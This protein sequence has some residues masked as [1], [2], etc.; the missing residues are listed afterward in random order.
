MRSPHSFIVR[1]KEARYKRAVDVG[2]GK[3]LEVTASIENAKDVDKRAVV[4]ATP[5]IYDG[6]I[7][8][9]DEVIIHHNIFR[10]YYNSKGKLTYTRAYLYD[11]LFYAADFEVFM[12][13]RD[14]RWMPHGGYTFVSP[15]WEGSGEIERKQ[16]HLG[17]VVASNV[18]PEGQVVGFTPESEYNI[19]IQRGIELYRMR[20]E[21]ICLYY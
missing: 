18:H 7:R 13:N 5:L 9:G 4:V 12:Y 19:S 6:P 8:E 11:D 1:P 17:E 10:N 3:R 14:G 16:R 2:N 20:D 21:D 15:I